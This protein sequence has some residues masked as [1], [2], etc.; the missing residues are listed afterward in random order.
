MNINDNEIVNY[1]KLR[2][3]R[4]VVTRVHLNEA[5]GYIFSKDEKIIYGYVNKEGELCKFN[6][7][8]DLRNLT[9]K[10]A[11]DIFERI[12]SVDAIS[13]TKENILKIIKEKTSVTE[14]QQQ[15]AMS[16][17]RTAIKGSLPY[18]V[19][20]T[21]TNKDTGNSM[22][23]INKTYKEED[24]QKLREEIDIYKNCVK[25]LVQDKEEI[26]SKITT[27]KQQVEEY[28][29]NSVS[30][31]QLQSIYTTVQNT[32]NRLEQ[33]VKNVIDYKIILN[34]GNDTNNNTGKKE[35]EEL[36]A[37]VKNSKKTYLAKRL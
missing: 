6:E 20:L 37:E 31:S 10:D 16:D 19:L 28:I 35:L 18:N 2:Y 25:T 3:P 13:E 36:Q 22:V 24:I 32:T 30:P 11:E 26:V 7:F 27:Y 12:P 23:E 17:L 8:V 15:K 34:K 9:E 33:I 4:I 14:E 21:T 5:A 1:I 29:K